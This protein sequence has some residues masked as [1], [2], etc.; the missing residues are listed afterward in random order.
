MQMRLAG[1]NLLS[2][3]AHLLTVNELL[4]IVV[5]L[6][7]DFREEV[8]IQVI[9][10]LQRRDEVEI[11]DCISQI[12]RNGTDKIVETALIAL[13]S[14][15]TIQSVE[16]LSKLSQQFVSETHRSIAQKQI[17]HQHINSSLDCMI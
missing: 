7:D 14:I 8:V 17:S 4:D 16:S 5:D 11:I 2:F 15:G 3:K 1:L 13:G 12:A 10:I 9:K 6:L